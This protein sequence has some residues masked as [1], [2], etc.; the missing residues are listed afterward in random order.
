MTHSG[1]ARRCP[2]CSDPGNVGARRAR[3]LSRSGQSRCAAS[4]ASATGG[5][6][7][8]LLCLLIWVLAG[9][10]LLGASIFRDALR[11]WSSGP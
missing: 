1:L 10:G 5:I 4:S 2:G 8:G 7:L 11:T 6:E 9:L 3:A